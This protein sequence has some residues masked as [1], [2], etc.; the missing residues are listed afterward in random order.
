MVNGI[1][2]N[3]QTTRVMWPL[4]QPTENTDGANQLNTDTNYKRFASDGTIT[5]SVRDNLSLYHY[6]APG[7]NDEYVMLPLTV[8]D[9][10]DSGGT[11]DIHTHIAGELDGCFWSG[12]TQED[13]SSF[14]SEDYIENS[15]GDRYRIFPCNSQSLAS[16]RYQ[17]ML[18]RED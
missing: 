9:T 17:Y 1:T 18:M 4:G 11:N 14:T 2:T 6:P 3:A 13:G 10:G 16:R 12:G 7:S 15:D 5:S 8:V